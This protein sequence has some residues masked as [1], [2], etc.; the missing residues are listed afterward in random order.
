M[1]VSIVALLLLFLPRIYAGLFGNNLGVGMASCEKRH[2]LIL[3]RWKYNATE[4]TI[5]AADATR[6][7]R[8]PS[9]PNTCTDLWCLSVDNT[10]NNLPLSG[11]GIGAGV[12]VQPCPKFSPNSNLST[13]S[14]AFR[15][16][17]TTGRVESRFAGRVPGDP[18]SLGLCLN[19]APTG[20]LE[21]GSCLNSS[22]WTINGDGMMSTSVATRTSSRELTAKTECLVAINTTANATGRK[23]FSYSYVDCDSLPGSLL[24]YCDTGLAIEDRISNLLSFLYMNELPTNF[25]R[26]G[27]PHSPPTGECLHGFA[28]DCIDNNT[29][30]T[31]FP[32]AL[33]SASS[34]N[35]SLFTAIGRAIGTEGRAITNVAST[36]SA[37]KAHNLKPHTI[38]WSPDLNPFRH[39]LWGRGQEV[40]SEDPLL[41]GRYGAGY[42]RG[43]Q[44]RDDPEGGGFLRMVASPKHFVG[45]DLEGMGPGQK[46]GNTLS[47]PTFNRHNFSNKM[48]AQELVEYYARPFELAVVQGGALGI[49]CSYNA[50]EVT[51]GAR[52]TGSVPACAFSGL[53]NGMVRGQWNFSGYIVSDCGAISDF[54]TKNSCSGCGQ[55]LPCHGLCDDANYTSKC[56]ACSSTCVNAHM[57]AGGTDAACGG[58]GDQIDA[59]KHGN[60]TKA[61]LVA[62]ARRVLRVLVSLGHANPKDKQPYQHLG[63]QDVD[64]AYTRQLNL[65]AARQSIVLL[66][67]EPTPNGT[68]LPLRKGQSVAVIGPIADNPFDLLSNY[69]GSPPPKSAPKHIV[70][71]LQALNRSGWNVSFQLG[72]HINLHGHPPNTKGIELAAALAASRDVAVVFVGLDA[73]EEHESGDRNATGAGLGLPGS[74]LQLVQAVRRANP[75]TA[76]VLIHGS[77]IAI[78]WS[79]EN[80]PAIVD[81]HYPGGMGGYGIA[82]VLT[83]AFNPCG[84][85]TTTVYSKAMARRSIFDTDLRADGGLTYMHYDGKTYGPTLWDFGDGISYSN[86]TTAPHGTPLTTTTTTAALAKSPLRFSVAITNSDGPGGCYT[87]LGFVGSKHSQAPRNRKLFDYTR[88]NVQAGHTAVVTLSLS[89]DTGSLVQSDGAK[90]VLPGS[91]TVEVAGVEFQLQL[92]GAAVAVAPAPPLEYH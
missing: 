42:I 47:G 5:R 19:S 10:I 11:G 78:E 63:K 84:R 3:D 77:A 25:G 17:S 51:D 53:Q 55:L 16:D 90:T 14:T 24:P 66:K 73:G 4:A 68:V 60:T 49:M 62:S 41:C 21:L 40:P 37:D 80:I 71:P 58:A 18:G 9:Q 2:K 79:K 85:L 64:S 32:D 31:I 13:Q 27:L 50:V 72:G 81:A 15:F 35:D 6:T 57:Y 20:V 59:L 39:P 23:G 65:E 29:C 36:E 8:V 26:L 87:A 56:P 74:Q 88:V 86:F 48:S 91:Y 69:H 75:N 83:G 44:G 7:C 1:S 12:F 22:S 61:E 52:T 43:L 82:D 34:F 33:A 67:N 45:Y 76:V 89:A 92:N 70:S 46:T 28:S 38:C 30:P 54:L